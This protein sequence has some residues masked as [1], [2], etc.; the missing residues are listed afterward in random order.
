MNEERYVPFYHRSVYIGE[1][2]KSYADY[3]KRLEKEKEQKDPDEEKREQPLS[4]QEFE[5]FKIKWI[6]A[7]ALLKQ[8]WSGI[9]EY[10]QT[11]N[12]KFFKR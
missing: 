3:L 10:I 6:M 9:E 5:V 2:P 8:D 1:M 4:K 11:E 12:T 7:T